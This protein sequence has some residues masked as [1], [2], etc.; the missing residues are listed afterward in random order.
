MLEHVEHDEQFA[1]NLARALKPGGTFVMTMPNGY[2]RPIPFPV[3]KRHYKGTDL[4]ALLKRHFAEVRVALRE[5]TGFGGLGPAGRN[6]LLAV[7]RKA[8]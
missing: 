1:A 2:F 8:A 6:H 4:E 7:C 3:H 5:R